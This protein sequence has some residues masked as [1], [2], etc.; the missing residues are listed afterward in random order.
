MTVNDF[1]ISRV[2][3]FVLPLA[4]HDGGVIDVL[5]FSPCL[6]GVVACIDGSKYRWCD[7][8]KIFPKSGAIPGGIRGQKKRY[9][10]FIFVPDWWLREQIEDD[11]ST[12]EYEW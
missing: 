9:Y 1:R 5:N 3:G 4:W 7:V 8:P 6:G 2:K 11:T 12:V 10:K